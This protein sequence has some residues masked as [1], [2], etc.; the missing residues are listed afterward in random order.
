MGYIYFFT[1][2]LLGRSITCSSACSSWNICGSSSVCFLLNRKMINVL[3]LLFSFSWIPPGSWIHWFTGEIYTGPKNVTINAT[4]N[5][6]FR[7]KRG[8]VKFTIKNICRCLLKQELL[9]QCNLIWIMTARFPLIRSLSEYDLVPRL[10]V[11]IYIIFQVFTGSNG[12]FMMYEDEGDYFNYQSGKFGLTQIISHLNIN[13]PKYS[14][15]E[16]RYTLIRLR[17]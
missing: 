9:C 13:F 5:G 16:H 14:L 15:M 3:S 11:N 7:K 2:V 1:R 10:Y 17:H 12:E 6:I 4:Y 8:R